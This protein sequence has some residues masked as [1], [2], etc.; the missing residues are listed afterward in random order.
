MEPDERLT[1]A[2]AGHALVAVDTAPLIYFLGGYAPWDRPVERLLSVAAAGRIGLVVSVITEAELLVGALR[3]GGDGPAAIA[4]LL[5]G[6]GLTVVPLSRP[7]AREAARLRSQIGLGLA[8]AVVAATALGVG[9]TA[10][11]GNDRRFRRLEG[12]LAYVHLD[13]LVPPRARRAAP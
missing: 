1:A 9:C 8:D 12:R 4:R 7:T 13:D 5:D 11:V 10:L 3:E 2:L 6:P